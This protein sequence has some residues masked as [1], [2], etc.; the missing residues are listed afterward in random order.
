MVN[1]RP[2]SPINSPDSPPSSS[3][4]LVDGHDYQVAYDRNTM[5]IIDFDLLYDVMARAG[6]H[7]DRKSD[8]NKIITLLTYHNQI[9]DLIKTAPTTKNGF[10]ELTKLAK[11]TS[12]QHSNLLYNVVLGVSAAGSYLNNNAES[13]GKGMVGLV[14][15]TTIGLANIAFGAKVGLITTVMNHISSTFVSQPSTVNRVL[16]VVGDNAKNGVGRAAV[17]IAEDVTAASF[18]SLGEYITNLRHSYNKYNITLTSNDFKA[19]EELF[20]ILKPSKDELYKAVFH[21]KK[22]PLTDT[23]F[24]FFPTVEG[25]ALDEIKKVYFNDNWELVAEQLPHQPI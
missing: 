23:P 16:G 21:V 12:G 10:Y 1:S 19:I 9:I 5:R 8:Q 18:R 15:D 22:Q 25:D 20:V 7:K 17:A 11:S 13:I 24:V 3:F 14:T 4:V 6:M 2:N